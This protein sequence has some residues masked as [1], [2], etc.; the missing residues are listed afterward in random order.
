MITNKFFR[1]GK[2]IG[3]KRD[4][5]LWHEMISNSTKNTPAAHVAWPLTLVYGSSVS[6]YNMTNLPLFE[7]VQ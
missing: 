7:K 4:I 5:I 3:F 2:S 1:K 6:H